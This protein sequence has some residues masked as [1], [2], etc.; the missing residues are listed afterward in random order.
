MTDQ[1]TRRTSPAPDGSGPP[2]GSPRRRPWAK[3]RSGA[4]DREGVAAVGR[5][6]LDA[7]AVSAWF[8]E[9]KVLDRVSLLMPSNQVTALIGPSGCGKSTFLR[10]FKVVLPGQFKPAP[11]QTVTAAWPVLEARSAVEK[12]MAAGYGVVPPRNLSP[13]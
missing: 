3:G 8:G 4:V 2:D 13:Q 9:H 12:A 5:G 11:G 10:T 7:R 1:L 6:E